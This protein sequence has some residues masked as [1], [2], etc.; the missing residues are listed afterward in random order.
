MGIYKLDF[1]I[2]MHNDSAM[3]HWYSIAEDG[4]EAVIK[5]QSTLSEMFPAAE[6][7]VELG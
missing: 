7:F 6:V 3:G 5:L 2:H 4:L 1:E